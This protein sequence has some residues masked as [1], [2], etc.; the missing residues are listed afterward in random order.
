MP[1]PYDSSLTDF[2]GEAVL[3]GTF[4]RLRPKLLVMVDRRIGRVLAARLPESFW[5]ICYGGDPH[6]GGSRW[7]QSNVG[8]CR[9]IWCGGERGFKRGG[10]GGKSARG[11]R[12]RSGRW[13]SGW[14]RRTGS[15]A[16]RR[17]S[18]STTTA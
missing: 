1:R 3:S 5:L 8:R 2:T 4:E 9:S 7:A 10:R 6:L 13:P 11:F 18:A 17:R 15:A 12:E 16:P 14:R